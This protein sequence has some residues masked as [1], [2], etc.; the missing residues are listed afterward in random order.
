MLYE[1]KRPSNES[2]TGE[3][4]GQGLPSLYDLDFEGNPK[5]RYV[6]ENT[7]LKSDRDKG[8]SKVLKYYTWDENEGKRVEHRVATSS[9][10]EKK[11]NKLYELRDELNRDIDKKA[12]SKEVGDTNP[13]YASYETPSRYN[14]SP[15][16]TSLEESRNYSTPDKST[17]DEYR[18]FQNAE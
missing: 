14:V 15:G 8:I 17:P 10:K 4:P 12:F 6:I 7:S 3:Q 16:S 13:N 5:Y 9:D 11:L 2:V 1:K 18:I